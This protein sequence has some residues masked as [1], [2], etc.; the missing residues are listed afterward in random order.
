MSLYMSSEFYAKIGR[1]S[2]QHKICR[3]LYRS[4]ANVRAEQDLDIV[5]CYIAGD[6]DGHFSMIT[7]TPYFNYKNGFLLENL[8]N[9]MY[10]TV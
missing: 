2:A 10:N 3:N 4:Y 1:F 9:C 6:T 5:L 8:S 7:K